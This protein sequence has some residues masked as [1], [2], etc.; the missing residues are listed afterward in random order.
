MSGHQHAI[1]GDTIF[2]WFAANDTSG[3][4]GDGASALY[5]VREAGAAASAAPLLS[6]SATLLSHAN[7]PPGAY[8]IAIAATTG[9]GFADNDVFAVFCTLSIDSQNPT[10]LVGSCSLRPIPANLEEYL[11]TDVA[12]TLVDNLDVGML[13]KSVITSSTGSP[14]VLTMA[15]NIISASNWIGHIITLTDVSLEE[16]VTRWVTA[17]DQTTNKI[18]INAPPPFTLED[19]VDI[20]RVKDSIHAQ[21]AIQNFA[22]ATRVE[23]ASDRDAIKADALENLQLTARKDSA[24]AND[25]SG[26]VTLLNANEGTGAGAYNNTTDSL[27]AIETLSAAVKLKTDKLTFDAGNLVASD[28]KAIHGTALKPNAAGTALDPFGPV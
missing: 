17:V 10:G 23:A 28:P 27:E 9:N 16:T 20:A 11:K 18:T 1:I 21:Y 2:F 22:P 25:L 14:L 4:G 24:I 19:A 15:T 5:D 12:G 6:G 7:Y 3:S 26:K 8:E 13:Y